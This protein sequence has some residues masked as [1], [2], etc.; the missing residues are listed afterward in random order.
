MV[1][2][3]ASSWDSSSR[4]NDF[5]VRAVF[6]RND[7]TGELQLAI[8]AGWLLRNDVTI[9][10]NFT[11]MLGTTQLAAG[12]SFSQ[13]RNGAVVSTTIGFNGRL[14]LKDNGEITWNF[15][16]NAT[17]MS[18]NVNVHVQVGDARVDS[19]LNLESVGGKVVGVRFLLG[20][21]F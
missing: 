15:Q 20:V 17:S 14:V 10:G 13:M 18:I 21:A 5:Q 2:R 6:H 12:F 1:D 4:L 9:G 3:Q 8:K 11:A 7:F 19:R 16:R